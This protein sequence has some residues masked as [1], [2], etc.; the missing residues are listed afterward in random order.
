MS[1]K[2]L[3]TGASGGIGYELA[4][5]FASRGNALYLAGR[6][7]EKLNSVQKEIREQFS[8]PVTGLALD[9]CRDQAPE[10]LF[11]HWEH[12]GINILV[13]NAGRG[14]FAPFGDNDR[15]Q[16]ENQI[17]LNISVLVELTRLFLPSF[18]KSSERSYILNVASLASF[19]PGVYM[20]GYFASK[21]YVLSFSEALAHELKKDN[22]VVTALCPGGTRTDFQERS[23]VIQEKDH[24]EYTKPFQ[25]PSFVAQ[26][27][28]DALMKGKIRCVPG[29]P[30]ALAAF[31]SRFLSPGKKASLVASAHR[32]RIENYRKAR[33]G[34][35]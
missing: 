18:K 7:E 1:H 33:Q 4:K 28:Y 16:E 34:K 14:L 27:G 30:Y 13:N 6:N 5:V 35:S 26:K 15:E 3:I 24:R 19:F 20:A 2:V 10:T 29:R 25:M 31:L 8:V 32:R 21:A 9:L 17:R 11:K 12:E 22:I 23:G